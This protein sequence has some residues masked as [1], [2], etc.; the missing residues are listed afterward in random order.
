MKTFFKLF[1]REFR[2]F[3]KTPVALLVFFGAPLFFGIA[4]GL[5]YKHADVSELPIAVVDYDNTQLS[6][7]IIDAINDNI[8]V[9]IETTYYSDIETKKLF[10]KGNIDAV[11]TIPKNFTADIQQ[12]RYPE[13]QVDVN[14]INI[15]TANYAT[16]GIQTSLLTINA[17]IEIESLI[18]KGMPAS[19]AQTQF[20][21]FKLNIDR[22][23]NPTANYLQFLWPGVLCTILQQVI[24]L[25][26]ALVFSQEFENHTFGQ[27]LGFSKSSI[28]LMF[29]KSLPYIILGSV[30][31]YALLYWMFP[32]FSIPINGSFWDIFWLSELFIVS[33]VFFGMMVSVIFKKQLTATEIL[34]IVAAPSFIISG[35][36]WPLSQMP[37]IVSTIA[38]CIPLTHFATGFR[39]LAYMGA[40]IS[41]LGPEIFALSM[42]AIVSLI[43]TWFVLH[44]KIKAYE[45]NIK[46]RYA[47]FGKRK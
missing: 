14:T 46:L 15:L 35:F 42:I 4:T 38:N 5:V 3:R 21:S 16:R 41:D 26:V 40:S 12:K 25:V 43:V 36:T 37:T 8:Y 19:I 31:W 44:F 13:I 28:M 32:F 9:N 17:G 30:L 27:L 1:I 20:E 11:V 24:L 47:I 34:M 18:K 2:L 7:K 6:R 22:H 23:Y 33:L 10:Q 29:V 39:K 45:K